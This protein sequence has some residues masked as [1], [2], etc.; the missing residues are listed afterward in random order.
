M[1]EPST[2]QCI[3]S[4]VQGYLLSVRVGNQAKKMSSTNYQCVGLIVLKNFFCYLFFN[5]LF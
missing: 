4:V 1:P 2:S 3:K 5:E